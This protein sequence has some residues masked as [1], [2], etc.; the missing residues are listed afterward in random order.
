M[1]L[2]QWKAGFGAGRISGIICVD[3]DAGNQRPRE[4][5]EEH[6]A[7]FFLTRD[8]SG[9]MTCC[10]KL[11]LCERESPIWRK[12]EQFLEDRSY[13]CLQLGF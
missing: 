6:S 13:A 3:D 2:I 12:L 9:Q 8:L 7:C 10:V 11:V 1:F 4:R 5:V